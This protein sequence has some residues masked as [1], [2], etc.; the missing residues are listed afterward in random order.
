MGAGFRSDGIPQHEL[1][2]PSTADLFYF[3]LYNQPATRDTAF[4]TDCLATPTALPVQLNTVLCTAS[5]TGPVQPA[6]LRRQSRPAS[7]AGIDHR[8]YH[9]HNCTI[10]VKDPDA[11]MPSRFGRKH[12]AAGKYVVEV[13]AAP[14]SNW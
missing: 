14:G 2:W 7:S 12:A 6:T 9:R 13:V 8:Q 5:T 1:S 3:T 10:C 4:S 11:P